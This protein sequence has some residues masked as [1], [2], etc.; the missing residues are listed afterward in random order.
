MA[1]SQVRAN[2]GRTA[3][4][5]FN[6]GRIEPRVSAQQNQDCLISQQRRLGR[7]MLVPAVAQIAGGG[8]FADN[9]VLGC[10]EVDLNVE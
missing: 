4:G 2:E 6:P 9:P 1:V 8:R 10:A 5:A 7:P 3:L